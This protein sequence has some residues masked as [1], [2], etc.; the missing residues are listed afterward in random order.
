MAIKYMG[1]VVLEVNGHEVEVTEFSVNNNTGRKLVKTMNST[2]RAKGYCEGIE[3]FELSMTVAMPLGDTSIDWENVVGAKLTQYP[4]G[5][6]QQI[7]YTDCFTTEVD[8]QYSVDNEARIS[9]K[10]NAL[11][12][13]VE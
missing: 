5:G 2:G 10:M 11:N 6:G 13:V 3:T 8:D 9:V 4:V 12:K 7:S 1:A